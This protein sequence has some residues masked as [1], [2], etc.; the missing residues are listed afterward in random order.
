MARPIRIE[1]EGALYHVTS[2]G[3]ERGKIYFTKADYRKFK[4]YLSDAQ[5]K[6]GF[7]LHGYVLMTNH[8]HLLIETPQMNLSKIMHHLNGSYTTYINTKRKRSGHLFQ[9]RYKAILVDRDSY[10]LELSRYLHLNPVRANMVE[11]PG[12]YP[13][14]SYGAYIAGGDELVT[15]TAVQSMISADTST[16]K[17]KYK[18]FVESVLGEKL[19]SPMKNVYGGMIL[20]NVEFIKEILNRLDD[21]H[22]QKTETSHKNALRASCEA[23]EVVSIAAKHYC[24]TAEIATSAQR[25]DIRK[26]CIYL[27]KR[28]TTATN[29]EIGQ[30]LGGMSG[31]AV[32]KAYQR[33]VAEVSQDAALRKE[34]GRLENRLSHVKG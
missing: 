1:Y 12:D 28:Q 20:G 6:Y 14:S 21:D 8:Y 4:E 33:M 25:N 3:N 19:E 10:L 9:G 22:L 18:S 13:H 30:L 31:F 2:R 17:L 5:I 24:V 7:V 29:Q 34:I 23:D 27:M 11:R 15:T 16:A 26:S 32:A